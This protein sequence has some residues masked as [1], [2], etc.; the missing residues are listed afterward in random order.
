[1]SLKLTE[2][3]AKEVQRIAEEQGLNS[4]SFMLRMGIRAGGCSGFQ[5]DLDMTEEKGEN[6]SEFESNGIR[7]ICDPKSLLYLE[8]TTL[9]FE[10]N[11][12]KRG[13]T[14]NNPQSQS[15]CGCGKSFCA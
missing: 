10:D 3:A 14:F 6:D 2:K 13:F 5:Y 1:V 9:D 4:D 8:G 12:N 11:L 15:C 7:I